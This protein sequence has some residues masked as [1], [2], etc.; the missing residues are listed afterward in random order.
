MAHIEISALGPSIQEQCDAQGLRATGKP[1]EIVDRISRALTLAHIHGV[2]TDSEIDRARARL[3]KAAKFAKADAG[4]SART[5]DADAEDA[6]NWDRPRVEMRER[7]LQAL[8]DVEA[9]L[10]GANGPT[11]RIRA[12]LTFLSDENFTLAA[13]QCRCAEMLKQRALLLEASAARWE[14]ATEDGA[15]PDCGCDEG[16]IHDEGCLLGRIDAATFARKLA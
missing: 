5:G 14:C 8:G 9:M 10:G 2:L 7:A 11:I 1:I 3:L 6:M 13:G 16:E 4:L 12:V 15:C